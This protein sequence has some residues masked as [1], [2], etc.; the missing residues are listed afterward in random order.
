MRTHM[1]PQS[2]SAFKRQLKDL[3][4]VARKQVTDAALLAGGQII[5]ADANSSAPGP[6]IIVEVV[7]GRTLL[8][9]KPGLRVKANARVVAVGPDKKHWYYQFAEYGARKHEISVTESG[10]IAFAG[11]AGIAIRQWAT[12]TGG[13]RMRAFMRRAMASKAAA[14]LKAIGNVLDNEIRKAFR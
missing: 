12:K 4:R 10:L 3:E 2:W 13:V 9:K 6:H 1:D 11:N 5:Q 7:Q 8:K 14:A